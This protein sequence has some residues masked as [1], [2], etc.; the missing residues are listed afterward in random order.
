MASENRT[1]DK[2]LGKE[3]RISHVLATAKRLFIEQGYSL[4]TTAQ[5]ARESDIAE[6]TL[7]RYFPSKRKLFEA[8]IEPLVSFEDFARELINAE[9]FHCAD[10]NKFIRERVAF[11]K[12]ERDLVRLV[13]LE[14]Q[15]QPDL[16]GEF[17][18]VD[19]V[20][21]QVRQILLGKGL[22][23]ETCKVIIQIVMGLLLSIA[24]TPHYDEEVIDTTVTLAESQI[25][26]LLRDCIEQNQD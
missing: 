7:F 1:K 19:N 16:A 3:E 12:R 8:V 26:E 20:A 9:N 15:F 5:V 23:Q 6:L 22:A 2:R 24:F 17:N 11:V 4:T 18:P 14:S 10:L 25:L 21:G 13:V